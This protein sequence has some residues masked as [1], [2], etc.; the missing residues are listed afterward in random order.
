[1]EGAAKHPHTFPSPRVWPALPYVLLPLLYSS[2]L[3]TPFLF[4]LLARIDARLVGAAQARVSLAPAPRRLR[5]RPLAALL[6]GSLRYYPITPAPVSTSAITPT[7]TP[8]SLQTAR[9][10]DEAHV[11][12]AHASSSNHHH[13]HLPKLHGHGLGHSRVRHSPNPDTA[14][15]NGGEEASTAHADWMPDVKLWPAMFHAGFYASYRGNSERAGESNGRAGESNGRAPPSGM[16]H[17]LSQSNSS[18]SSVSSAGHSASPHSHST[19]TST[20]SSGGTKAGRVTRGGVSAANGAESV[21]ECAGAARSFDALAFVRRRPSPSV[22]L[23]VSCFWGPRLALLDFRA[24]LW[25]LW[26]AAFYGELLGRVALR[27]APAPAS[28]DAVD[29]CGA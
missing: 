27:R 4:S 18:Y 16:I 11:A 5:P 21:G 14:T 28:L 10:E 19:S 22:Y 2:L 23:R 7:P 6:S 1:M 20:T 3:C 12:A 25:H 29:A 15:S 24:R 26:R 9:P 13:H 17:N 8:T